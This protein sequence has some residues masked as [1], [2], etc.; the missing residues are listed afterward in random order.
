MFMCNIYLALT[1][2]EL[3]VVMIWEHEH[4]DSQ[5]TYFNLRVKLHRPMLCFLFSNS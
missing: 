2:H 5:Q 4:V 3:L 1:L